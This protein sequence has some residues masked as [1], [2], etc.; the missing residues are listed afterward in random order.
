MANKMLFKLNIP[1]EILEQAEDKGL[2]INSIATDA[3]LEALN[4]KSEISDINT[5]FKSEEWTK[6]MAPRLRDDLNKAAPMVSLIDNRYN[7]KVTATQLMTKARELQK[8]DL[9]RPKLKGV[10]K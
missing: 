8:P 4:S 10:V 7:L 6:K 5:F 3:I 1:R 2:H 9:P